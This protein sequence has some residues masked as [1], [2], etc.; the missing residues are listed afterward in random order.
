[1]LFNLSI[2][3]GETR[4]GSRNIQLSTHATRRGTRLDI[5]GNGN[6]FEL[7]MTRHL[8]GSAISSTT[9]PIDRT[10]AVAK[11]TRSAQVPTGYDAFSMLA[12][13]M[14]SPDVV[15]THAPTRNLELGPNC[16]RRALSQRVGHTVGRSLGGYGLGGEDLQL[17][18]GDGVRDGG[19][20]D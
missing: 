9:D 19:H 8:I 20:D 2:I 13:T 1:M 16:I 12:P 11:A 14:N 18:G 17:L 3:D 5:R 4:H 10:I 7:F 15:R 6:G